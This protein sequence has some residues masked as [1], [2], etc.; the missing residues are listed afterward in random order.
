VA[1]FIGLGESNC[2]V[3]VCWSLELNIDFEAIREPGCVK[4][5]LLG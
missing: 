1:L 3:E 4:V 2:H 5:T